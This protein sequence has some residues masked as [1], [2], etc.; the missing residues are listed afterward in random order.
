MSEWLYIKSGKLYS[1]YFLFKETKQVGGTAW[2]EKQD[3]S[4]GIGG[5]FNSLNSS[6]RI[7]QI[8][9]LLDGFKKLHIN[10]YIQFLMLLYYLLLKNIE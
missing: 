10:I 6:L 4:G 9:F 5:V 2:K 8:E 7:P 3:K 1:N